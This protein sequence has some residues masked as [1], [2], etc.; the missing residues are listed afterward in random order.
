M[1][2]KF[3]IAAES[4]RRIRRDVEGQ[5]QTALK[6]AQ[7]LVGQMV[8]TLTTEGDVV[9]HAMSDKLGDGVYFHSLNV[10][11]LSLMLA[12]VL[13]LS[14]SDMREIGLGALFHDFGKTE[15]PDA[16]LLKTEP[17]TKP[18]R[19]FL[20]RHCEYG[21]AI[22]K[23]AGLAKPAQD[24]VM[25]HHE[26]VDGSGYPGKLVGE[27][28]TQ[29]A[30]LVCVVNTYDNLC[31]P[32]NPAAALTPAEALAQ[33]FALNRTMFDAVQFQAFIHCLGVYPPGSVV[34]L[35][36]EMPGLVLSANPSK[37]L[38]PNVLVYDPDAPRDEM[39]IVSLGQEPDLR[40]SRSLRPGQLPREVYRYLNPRL[41]VTYYFDLPPPEE[42]P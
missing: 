13:K 1:E 41:R 9:I 39:V 25:Q 33:M 23:R 36:N 7:T 10:T 32:V 30:R 15:I 3:Q 29:L 18:E 35:S 28:I 11:V 22:A 31:N 26:H 27:Q 12:R 17:L 34:Q 4:V 5:P 40:I 6:E 19:S 16:I 24:I 2:K 14:A 20:E 38:R 42:A 8:A 37:P 21:L